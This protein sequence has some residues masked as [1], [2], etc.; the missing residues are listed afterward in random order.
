MTGTSLNYLMWTL[1]TYPPKPGARIA[2]Y[3][4]TENIG[5]TIVKDSLAAGGQLDY[6]ALDFDNGI[7]LRLPIKG[8]KFDYGICMDLLEHCS[9]PFLV[10]K[11]IKNSLKKGAVLMVTAPFVWE[12][13]YYPKDYW[14]FTPQGVEELFNDLYIEVIGLVRDQS[15]KET[16]PRHRIVGVF[17][18]IPKVDVP[19]TDSVY[20]SGV[21]FIKDWQITKK[22][23]YE[24]DQRIQANG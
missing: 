8:K 22:T 9:D 3:G 16:L 4:G 17:R 1:N 12:L 6:T 5:D 18:K 15:P 10:A 7:D 19:H 2:D 20:G 21:D 13:H 11:N 23:N 14:R 24:T